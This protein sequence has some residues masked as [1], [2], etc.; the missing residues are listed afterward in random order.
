MYFPLVISPTGGVLPKL[1]VLPLM[2]LVQR[3]G[4][5]IAKDDKQ[6]Y[7]EQK[8]QNISHTQEYCVGR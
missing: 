1:L 4:K 2:P 8:S 5:Y 3:T 6:M 7:N